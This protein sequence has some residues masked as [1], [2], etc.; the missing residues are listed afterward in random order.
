M[1]L[2]NYEFKPTPVSILLAAVFFTLFCLLGRWQIHRAAEKQGI[3]AEITA[4]AEAPE[5]ELLAETVTQASRPLWYRRALARGHY[6]ARGQLLI[7]NILHHGKPGFYVLTPL[8]LD[9]GKTRVLVNRGWIPQGP[10]RRQL[11]SIRVPTGERVVHGRIDKGPRQVISMGRPP[12]LSKAGPTLWL[13]LDYA[14][15]ARQRGVPLLP[16]TLNLDA[17]D[18][19]GFARDW[20]AFRAKTGMH[21]GYAIQWFAFAVIVLV[22]F[23]YTGLRRGAGEDGRDSER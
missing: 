14:E 22:V 9:D 10:D 3:A 16:L 21:Y 5:I 18:P 11:P 8:L 2:L 6:E 19:A 23:I 13:A 1:R 12:A 20:P 4:R 15:Y 17:D 7:D